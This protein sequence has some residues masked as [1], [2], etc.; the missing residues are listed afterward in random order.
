MLLA[1]LREGYEITGIHVRIDGTALWTL[2][3]RA[4]GNAYHETVALP[5]G[6]VKPQ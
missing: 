2:L 1:Y 6:W 3:K 4:N 5:D